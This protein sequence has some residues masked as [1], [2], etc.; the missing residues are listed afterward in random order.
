MTVKINQS[1]VV[2]FAGLF[3]GEG[4]VAYKQYPCTDKRYKDKKGN[5]KNIYVG[6]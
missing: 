5:H 4:H 6:L 1:D 3:D 2:Y